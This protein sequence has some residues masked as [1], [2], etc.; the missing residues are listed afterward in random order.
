MNCEKLESPR[1]SEDRD[2]LFILPY[3]TYIIHMA[4]PYSSEI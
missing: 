4:S 2:R 1:A 3:S